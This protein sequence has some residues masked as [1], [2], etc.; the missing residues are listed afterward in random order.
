MI[1][2]FRVEAGELREKEAPSGLS[3]RS[4]DKKAQ[5][6]AQI[7]AFPKKKRPACTGRR[8]GDAIPGGVNWSKYPDGKMGCNHKVQKISQ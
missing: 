6:S 7:Q 5:R 8:S 4:R 2:D 1:S 3:A